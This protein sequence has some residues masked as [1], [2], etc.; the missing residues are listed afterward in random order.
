MADEEVKNPQGGDDGFPS[1]LTAPVENENEEYEYEYEYVEV[2]ESEAETAEENLLEE[3]NEFSLDDMLGD[4]SDDLDLTSNA[5]D[6]LPLLNE[7]GSEADILPAATNDGFPLQEEQEQEMPLDADILLPE[8][9][10][11]PVLESA[12]D[13][14]SEVPETV[15]ES[16]AETEAVSEVAGDNAEISPEAEGD[17]LSPQGSGAGFSAEPDVQF[18]EG[19]EDQG[20][21]SSETDTSI[22]A[23]EMP[24]PESLQPEEGESPAEPAAFSSREDEAFL[25]LPDSGI[26]TVDLNS[27]N[28]CLRIAASVVPGGHSW[29]WLERKQ[30]LAE[31]GSNGADLEIRLPVPG[32]NFVTLVKGGDQKLEL[33]N[34]T[35]LRV[36]NVDAQ[37]FEA[38]DGD[39]ILGNAGFDSGAV[40]EEFC[41]VNPADLSQTEMIFSEPAAGIISGPGTVAFVNGLR[42]LQWSFAETEN[43]EKEQLRCLK[44]Y[45]GSSED[46]YFELSGNSPAA[47]FAG[48]EEINSI[49]VNCGASTYGWNVSF[50][51]GVTMSLRDLREYQVRYGKMPDNAGIISCGDLQVSFSNIARIVVY[52]SAR[53]FSYR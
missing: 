39:F 43:Y 4:V 45:S 10:E 27:Y 24:L 20:F 48:N 5:E 42:C 31:I 46:K 34:R 26:Q 11:E 38:V 41:A 3:E 28:G 21:V 15:I 30:H 35:H 49:H 14:V 8:A 2:P 51:N 22:A 18:P 12:E 37:A 9:G 29:F 47:A 53:Y 19:K 17:V 36:E 52:E 33:F 50:E 13:I 40:I 1:F 44:S 16:S 7:T 23:E 25:L 32:A 6:D